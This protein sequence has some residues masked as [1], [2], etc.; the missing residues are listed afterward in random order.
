MKTTVTNK[1]QIVIP[2]PL[3]KKF[4]IQSGTIVNVVER[5]GRIVLE[6][7]TNEYIKSLRGKAAGSGAL[8]DLADQREKDRRQENDQ[9]DI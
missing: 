6:P 5:E 8:K 2:A 7:V 1:G 4:Q 9:A 3:R